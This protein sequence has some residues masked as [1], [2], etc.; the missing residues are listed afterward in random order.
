MSAGKY[1]TLYVET[2]ALLAAQE[3]DLA[4]VQ[5]LVQEMLPG[6]RRELHIACERLMSTIE[7]CGT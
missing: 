4:E 2:E 1:G 7:W 6:E 5:R 3:G